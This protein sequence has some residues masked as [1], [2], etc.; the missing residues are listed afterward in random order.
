[1]RDSFLHQ[2]LG[3]AVAAV[4][5]LTTALGAQAPSQPHPSRSTQPHPSRQSSAAPDPVRSPVPGH[6]SEG[7]DISWPNCP[8]GLG[9]PSRRT[10][11]KPLPLPGVARFVV[12]GLTNGPGFHANPCLADQVAYA[13]S[14]HLSA[15]PY[16]VV[17]YP[18]GDELQRYGGAGPRPPTGRRAQLWNTGWAQATANVARMR[19][20]GLVAPLVW[21]D[22]EPV[23]PPT[24]WSG[25]LRAN[26]AVLEGAL[27]AYRRADL[28]IGVYSTAY[29]WRSIVG[30][31][32]YGLPEWRPTGPKTRQAALDL[33]TRGEIQGGEPVLVQWV[34]GDVDHDLLCPGRPAADVLRE[35][36]VQL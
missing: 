35:L 17:T 19:L 1:M 3:A 36:F 6:G 15:A 32:R 26:R 20:A 31:A 13:R 21:V 16:A 18:T 9:I 30:D 14:L 24:P 27:A 12:I 28:R 10:L 34:S 8:P 23:R 4:L 25:D 22:V 2:I 7:S 33:C 5:S 29:L 11:G